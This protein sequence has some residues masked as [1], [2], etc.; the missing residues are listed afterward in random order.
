MTVSE[1]IS[2]LIVTDRTYVIISRRSKKHVGEAGGLGKQ[3][4]VGDPHSIPEEYLN[5]VFSEFYPVKE[6]ELD[7]YFNV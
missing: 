3:L 4:Y 6:G 5:K 1:L 7:I 2:K